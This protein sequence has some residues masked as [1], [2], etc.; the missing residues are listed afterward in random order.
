MRYLSNTT[1]GILGALGADLN[2]TRLLKLQ[3]TREIASL[4]GQLFRLKTR[5]DVI[6]YTTIETYEEMLL[7]RQR[8]L[9]TLSWDE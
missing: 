9:E 8:I 1:T 4:E 2:D 7:S 3:L 6:D 5:N